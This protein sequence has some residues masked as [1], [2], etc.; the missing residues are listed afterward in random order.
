MT[1]VTPFFNAWFVQSVLLDAVRFGMLVVRVL[2]RALIG[3][4]AGA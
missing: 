4:K 2:M 1:W 3:A